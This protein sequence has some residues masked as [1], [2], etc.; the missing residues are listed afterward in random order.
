MK[1]K[2]VASTMLRNLREKPDLTF[3]RI[4]HTGITSNKCWQQYLL[5]VKQNK[6]LQII[7]AI[8]TIKLLY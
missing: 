7:L 8:K 5:L 4:A 1:M 2:L 6:N 3:T